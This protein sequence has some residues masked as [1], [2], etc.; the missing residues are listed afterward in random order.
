MRTAL[1]TVPLLLLFALVGCGCDEGQDEASA[2]LECVTCDERGEPEGLH[3]YR[4]W[5]EKVGQGAQPV[6]E[7]AF[8]NLAAL[9]YK[10]VLSVDGAA[11]E[12]ELAAKHGLRY[13]HVPIGYD[14]IPAEAALQ[15]V[16][17]TLDLD[18]PIYV[19]CH[20]GKHRGPAAAMLCRIAADGISN[21]TALEGLKISGTSKSYKGLYRDVDM[22]RAPSAETLAGVSADLPSKVLPEGLR[23]GM[24]KISHDWE[25]LKLCEEAGWNVPADHPDVDPP[26]EARM[27]WETFRE[28]GRTDK[29]SRAK[30]EIYLK[31]LK[32]SEDA[33]IE[34]EK[35]IRAGDVET[36]GVKFAEVKDLCASCHRDYRN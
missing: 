22:F 10:T 33:A 34:L 12:V 27:L 7:A 11:T 2:P 6:G 14:G 16:K 23:A 24:V 5:S 29:E 36:A 32:A 3:R 8:R 26:H 17:A 25:R 13:V 9:G 28:M 15:I 31:Y 4:R 20:H 35:A 18:G 19:H 1:A 30:G 21:A